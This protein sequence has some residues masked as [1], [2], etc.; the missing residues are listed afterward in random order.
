MPESTSTRTRSFGGC[1]TVW[2]PLI[3]KFF[4]FRELATDPI[5]CR[6]RHMKCDEAKPKCSTCTAY[7]LDCDGYT[8][9]IFFEVGDDEGPTRYRQLL[10]SDIEREQMNHLMTKEVPFS[11]THRTIAAIDQDCETSAVSSETSWSVRRGPFGAFKLLLGSKINEHPVTPKTLIRLSSPTLSEINFTDPSTFQLPDWL[12]T[13]SLFDFDACATS[14]FNTINHMDIQ[15][16][17]GSPTTSIGDSFDRW[18]ASPGSSPPCNSSILEHAPFLLKH[19]AENIILSLTPFKHTKT[20]WHVLFL[21]N[22]KTTL[23]SLA[24]GDAVDDANMTTFLGIL[25]ISALSI[26]NSSLA[27]KWHINA[28]VF[29]SRAQRHLTIVLRHALDRPKVFKYKTILMAIITMIQ[30]SV[31]NDNYSRSKRLTCDR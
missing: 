23:A 21:P 6:S 20:P 5:Q 29:G 13:S 15:E 9:N 30:V 12:E 10:F 14:P 26:H 22:A 1:G 7:G 24:M 3:Q 2:Q 8:R 17:L 28:S 19:Y 18:L 4:P 25:A 27:N 16:D 11:K 31:S